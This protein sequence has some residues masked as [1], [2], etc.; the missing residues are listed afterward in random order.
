MTNT[1][2][3]IYKATSVLKNLV[4]V[5]Q[6]AKKTS[7]PQIE[8][9]FEY[10][11]TIVKNEQFHYIIDLSNTNPPTAEVRN[12]VKEKLKAFDNQI[13]S[14]SVIIGHN[15]LLKIALKFVGASLGLKDF[16]TYN[17]ITSAIK[18]LER[19]Y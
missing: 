5:Y 12:C 15:F 19:E 14:Y 16:K 17:S 1:E 3:N 10:L 9:Y 2:T 13:L 18:Y 7:T 11:V 8:E 4:I 6:E